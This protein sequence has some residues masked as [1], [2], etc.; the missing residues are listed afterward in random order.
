MMEKAA[1]EIRNSENALL[2]KI[3]VGKL[4]ETRAENRTYRPNLE[5]VRDRVSE[6]LEEEAKNLKKTMMMLQNKID[7]LKYV[8]N[9]T[10]LY[11]PR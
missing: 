6:G 8:L 7:H 3:N 2:A 5:L 11:I 1:I 9:Q 10:N 4:V